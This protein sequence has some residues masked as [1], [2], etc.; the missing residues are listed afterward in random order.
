MLESHQFKYLSFKC[1]AN[2]FSSKDNNSSSILSSN[3][4]FNKY[5]NKPI[6]IEYPGISSYYIILLLQPLNDCRKLK[7]SLRI[8]FIEKQVRE[9]SLLL[10]QIH[11]L[12]PLCNSYFQFLQRRNAIL[13]L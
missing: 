6:R 5:N 13:G 8:R 10:V 9:V 11:L 7:N 4:W 2:G 3:K 12:K 1:L